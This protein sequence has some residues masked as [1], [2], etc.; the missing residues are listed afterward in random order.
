MRNLTHAIAPLATVLLLMATACDKAEPDN[1]FEPDT[2]GGGGDTSTQ[3]LSYQGLAGIQD[4][5]F[6]PTCANAGCHDGTFE[7]DFRT[8]ASSYATL[9]DHPVIKND[10]ADSY[11]YRVVPGN[12]EASQLYTRITAD[13]DGNSGIMPLVLEP[14]SDYNMHRDTYIAWIRRWIAEGAKRSE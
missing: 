8:L 7:P 4:R 13:I 11:E 1:P 14:D 6:R 3:E 9:V 10:P 5:I 2:T 12:I